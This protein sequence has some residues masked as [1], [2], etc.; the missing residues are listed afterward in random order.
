[1]SVSTIDKIKTIQKVA[2]L[3]SRSKATNVLP[4]TEPEVTQQIKQF[5]LVE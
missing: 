5:L 3:Q 4:V 1:M 2:K